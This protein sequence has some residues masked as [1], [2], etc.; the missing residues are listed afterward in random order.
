LLLS[1]LLHASLDPFAAFGS[2]LFHLVFV[3]EKFFN[4]V[5]VRNVTTLLDTRT[6]CH[7]L[8]PGFE[9]REFV[10]IDACPTCRRDPSIVGDI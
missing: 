1:I 8:L 3:L 10:N 5:R 6:G 9:R 7:A 2:V 4:G